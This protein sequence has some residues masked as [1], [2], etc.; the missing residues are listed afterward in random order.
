MFK[1]FSPLIVRFQTFVECA[2]GWIYISFD[3]YSRIIELL[4]VLV[5]RDVALSACVINILVSEKA[6]TLD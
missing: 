2:V 6:E 5:F 3:M 4:K 1:F